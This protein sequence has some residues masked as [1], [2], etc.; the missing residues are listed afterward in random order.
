MLLIILIIGIDRTLFGEYMKILK[1][2]L[3]LLCPLLF[4]ACFSNKDAR[5]DTVEANLSSVEEK[6]DALL[7]YTDKS[8]DVTTDMNLRLEALDQDAKKRG[9]PVRIKGDD[10][11][12]ARAELLRIQGKGPVSGIGTNT[13]IA[14]AA[15]SQHQL[16]KQNMNAKPTT[17][18]K[19]TEGKKNSKKTAA[20]KANKAQELEFPDHTELSPPMELGSITGQNLSDK[21]EQAQTPQANVQLPA[22]AANAN[23]TGNTRPRPR[24]LPPTLPPM[25]PV[26]QAAPATQVSMVQTPV[27]QGT[28]S[29]IMPTTQDVPVTTTQVQTSLQR[30]SS[31]SYNTAMALYKSKKYK[32]AEQAFDSFLRA[33]PNAVLAPN[34]LYWKGETFY[35]RG[36]YPQAIFAF[37]EVQTRYPR[38]SK[39]PDSLLK[40]AMSYA[41]IGDTENADL[42]YLV[43]EED[44]PTSA[45]AK[46]IPK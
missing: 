12:A 2:A 9:V 23:I 8:Y 40:T 21:S 25:I 39:A 44:F 28:A 45:A 10:I 1:L 13:P 24:I 15:S 20:T 36:D 43:L 22:T 34:A 37:K 33:N 35:A 18:N 32:K 31:Q 6:I 38:H 19:S 17:P 46:R 29:N 11:E 41:K 42:H 14:L 26:A 16:P 3:F 30:G 5:L 7:S 27:I 4:S